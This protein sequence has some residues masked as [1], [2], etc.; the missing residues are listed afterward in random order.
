[1]SIGTSLFCF[2]T[3]AKKIAVVLCY[4]AVIIV[5][6][7]LLTEWFLCDNLSC[8]QRIL[9]NFKH[10][11]HW[12]WI[13]VGI[14]LGYCNSTGFQTRGPKVQKWMFLLFI[15]KVKNTLIIHKRKI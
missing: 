12:H 5:D 8:S 13:K 14:D 6:V 4:G 3:T 1:M 11:N 2:Y 9:P 15:I 10:N 7:C